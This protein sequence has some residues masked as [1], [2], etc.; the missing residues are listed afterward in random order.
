MSHPDV[1]LQYGLPVLTITCEDTGREQEMVISFAAPVDGSH[2]DIALLHAPVE[3]FG[4]PEHDVCEDNE[5]PHGPFQLPDFLVPSIEAAID[6]VVPSGAPVWLEFREPTGLTPVVPW[7]ALLSRFGHPVLRLPA[8]SIMPEAPSGSFDA[9]VCFSSPRSEELLPE[10]L[11]EAF[12]EQ[13]PPDLAQFATF[14]LFADSAVQPLLRCVR[15]H[16]GEEFRIMIYDPADAPDITRPVGSDRTSEA[17]E[18]PWLLWM[19]ESLRGQ[20]A[21]VVHFLCHGYVRRGHGGI[22]LAE[23]PIRNIDPEWAAFISAGELCQFLNDV[24]AW[25]VAFTSPPGNSSPAGLWLLQYS[26]A[27]LRPGPV[28]LHD[29]ET[30]E[31]ADLGNAYR[32]LYMP[33]PHP[34][35]LS[36]GI[37]LYCHPHHV[38]AGTPEA[39]ASSARVL[40]DYTLAG[41]VGTVKQSRWVAASQRILE[42]AAVKVSSAADTSTQEVRDGAENALRWVAGVIA[43]HAAV[44]ASRKDKENA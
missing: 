40:N 30:V 26:V 37:S 16:F 24:G 43:K 4:L 10:R 2:R 35:P 25:S 14:H 27:Q 29:M 38:A 21:D 34:P 41:K 1:K 42:Q 17:V 44:D 36:R 5:M 11:V 9:V 33:E 13:I 31:Q 22:A 20:T 7:E 23:S 12:V 18:N 3:L 39:D 32:F 8:Q 6:S 19:R 28:L 15:D